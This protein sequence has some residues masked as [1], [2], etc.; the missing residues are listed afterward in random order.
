MTSRPQDLI[1][2]WY[3]RIEFD[4]K[5]HLLSAQR[6]DQM[7]HTIGLFA[8]ILGTIAGTTLLSE[9]QSLLPRAIAGVLGLLAAVLSGI[10]TFYSYARRAELHRVA[11]A[12]LSQIRR[13]IEGLEKLPPKYIMNQT[14][15]F[16]HIGERLA[17]MGGTS[18]LSIIRTGTEEQ[19]RPRIRPVYARA[20][21]N[22]SCRPAPRFA[23][24]P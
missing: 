23:G 18:N 5:A 22:S 15:V 6:L 8:V 7:Y 24:P 3:E 12:Q 2:D 4:R 16:L 20:V 14:E 13:Q 19:V 1:N 10:L 11:E 17:L 21:S 9:T